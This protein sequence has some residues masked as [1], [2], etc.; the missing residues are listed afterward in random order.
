MIKKTTLREIKQSLGRYLAIM[1]IVALGV[2]LFAG[3]KAT[4]P[5]MHITAQKYL[6]EHE[7]YDYRLLS[8]MGFD[9]EDA[10]YYKL[11]EG[12][13]AAEGAYTFDILYLGTDGNESVLKAHSLS[14]NINKLEIQ[15]GRLPKNDSECVV[16][17][18]IFSET[19]IGQKIVLSDSNDSDDLDCFK[20]KEY[21]ITGIVQSP[22]YI[23]FERGNTSLGN[24]KVAGFMY[25]LPEGFDS[26]YYTELFVKFQDDFTLYSD[27]YEAFLDEKEVVWENLV[28]NRAQYNFEE[29]VA[30]AEEE[31]AEAEAELATEK[32]DAE[33]ELADAKKELEDAYKELTDAEAELADGEKEILDGE[34]EISDGEKE[35]ADAEIEIAENE[36]KLADGEA[37]L[38]EQEETLREKEQEFNEAVKEWYDADSLLRQQKKSLYEKE[39][40]LKQ[41][42]AEAEAGLDFIAQNSAVL[43]QKEN[44][45]NMAVLAGIMSET[46]AAVVQARAEIAAG[47]T[48][49]A[50]KEAEALAGLNVLYGYLDQIEEG[51]DQIGDAEDELADAWAQ[52]TDAKEQIIDGWQKIADAKQEIVDGKAEIADAKVELADAKKDIEQAKIDIEDAKTEVADGKEELADGWIEYYDGLKEYEDGVEEFE[53]EIADAMEEIADAKEELA[54]LE[55]PSTYV[56]GRDTNV[57]YVCFESDSTIVE[58]IAGVF[59]VFFFLV[60]ALVCMTTMNRMVEEQRTQIGV[61]KALGYGEWTIMNKY[62]FY[63]GSSAFLGCVLGFFAGTWFFPKVIWYAYGIMYSMIPLEYVFDPVMAMICLAASLLCSMGTTWLSCRRELLEVSAQLMRPKSPKAGKRVLLEYLPFIWNRLKFLHKVSVRNIFRYKKRFFMMIIGISGCT[64][65][66]VVGFGMR[67]SVTSIA[68]QQYEEIQVYDLGIV[69]A[70]S[71]SEEEEADFQAVADVYAKDYSFAAEIAVDLLTGEETKP[72]NLIIMQDP[73][74]VQDYIDLHTKKG[75]AVPY[76][77]KGEIVVCQKLADSYGL[78]IGDSVSI[79]DED[80]NQIP[81]TVSGVCEN[82]IF[83][84]VYINGETYEEYLGVKPEYKSIFMN[85][86]ENA[87]AH[88][89]SAEIMALSN[90]SSVTVNFD[91]MGRFASMMGSLDY[92]VYVV[93]LC[94]AALAFIVLYNLTNINITE[95]IR[96]IATIK[97]L[98]FFKKET[99]SYVFRENTVLTG[100]GAFVGLGLGFLLHRFVMSKIVV[101]MVSFDVHVKPVSYFISFLLTFVF[102]WFIN[103]LMS[104]KLEKINM[105]ESLKSVD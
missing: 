104:G 49:L 21:T 59:P 29:L 7:F 9:E 80:M 69:Y 27:E 15:A 84:Y 99:A 10:L 65:L 3:L 62:L 11:Q 4:K 89:A 38:A 30:D 8:T 95:R 35:I 74:V 14:Q 60:A 20:H 28:Q 6:D 93:I 41:G 63:S 53:T 12:V 54:D 58:N 47:R 1:A 73:D 96:E 18:N 2:G 77:E 32:A 64:A 83:N 103:R 67:D 45:L 46:D 5:A 75:E 79:Q 26:E 92:I 78:K 66:L 16:D 25:L 61:L 13:E 50:A 86:K 31:I 100:I 91:M 43:D 23:Q 68:T 52:I 81:V 101:D 98:G 57:G 90:V 36:Q 102:S 88:M 24:G 87:D 97:V 19:Q 44:E 71:L 40:Q 56:L 51:K 85:M 22:Y 105:A 17:A 39:E 48:Q 70:D 76:P 42:V 72:V 34:K 37:E 82:F 33:A 94:A 55:E